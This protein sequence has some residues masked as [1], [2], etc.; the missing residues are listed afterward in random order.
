MYS[1]ILFYFFIQEGRP[2]PDV[3]TAVA[4]GQEEGNCN[5][6]KYNSSITVS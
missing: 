5:D 4:V 2:E 6:D 3:N 1:A